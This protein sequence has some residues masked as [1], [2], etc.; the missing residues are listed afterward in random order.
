[1]SS[2]SANTRRALAKEKMWPIKHLGQIG[3]NQSENNFADIA[4]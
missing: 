4:Y 1:M 3:T 2:N